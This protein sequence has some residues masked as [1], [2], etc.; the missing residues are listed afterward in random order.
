VK[1]SS[2]GG[3]GSFLATYHLA[4]GRCPR[5]L[6]SQLLRGWLGG[7][8]GPGCQTGR[9]ARPWLSDREACSDTRGQAGGR[10]HT[11][12]VRQEGML[13]YWAS[14]RQA[15]LGEVPGCAPCVLHTQGGVQDTWGRCQTGRRAQAGAPWRGRCQ[16]GR[17]AGHKGSMSDREA[18]RTQ[19]VHVRQGG[20]QDTRGPCQTGRRTLERSMS[21]ISPRWMVVMDWVSP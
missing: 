6:P 18:C 1:G 13:R 5:P 9:R 2:V 20:V 17:R 21:G 3:S 4:G 11:Q 7:V 16:T 12:G 19:G 14:L 8:Q 15:H 10:A